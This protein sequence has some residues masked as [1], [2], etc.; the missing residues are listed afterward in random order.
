MKLKCTLIPLHFL[1]ARAITSQAVLDPVARDDV[2]AF[3]SANKCVHIKPGSLFDPE[4]VIYFLPLIMMPLTQ[5]LQTARS[6]TQI[7]IIVVIVLIIEVRPQRYILR[8]GVIH[9]SLTGWARWVCRST[10]VVR[11]QNFLPGPMLD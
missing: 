8:R 2:L 10:T 3:R 6:S 1:F 7:L 9:C 5:A 4:C 11:Q